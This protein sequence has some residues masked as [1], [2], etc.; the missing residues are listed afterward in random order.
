MGGG[1][2]CCLHNI[3]RPRA[4]RL[5]F[6]EQYPGMVNPLDGVRGIVNASGGIGVFFYYIKIVPTIYTG[7][8]VIKTNQFSATEQF[9]PAMVDGVRQNVLPGVFVVYDFSA[10][11]VEVTE[12][13]EPFFHFLT[14]LCAIVGGVFTVCVR[15][16]V[17]VC[18]CVCVCV[19]VCVC[20][21]ACVRVCVCVCVCVCPCVCPCVFVCVCC[22]CV[23]ACVCVFVC[24]CVSLCVVR[25]CVCVCVCVCVFVFVC[26]CVC[27][28]CV[29]VCARV[30]VCP[31]LCVCV[32]ARGLT[33]T[34]RRSRAWSTL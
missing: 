4:R 11:M 27:V 29:F 13:R 18:L 17:R 19:V 24:V 10:F 34:C 15:V 8:S 22:V 9:R 30:F 26:V 25:V 33:H 16:C 20:V 31:C 5:S 28:W 12:S 32:R 7:A 3:I 2:S 23:C 6:G 1:G 14:G 21:C